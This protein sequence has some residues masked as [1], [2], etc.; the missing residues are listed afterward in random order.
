MIKENALNLTLDVLYLR[1]LS[2][3]PYGKIRC[4]DALQEPPESGVLKHFVEFETIA[5]ETQIDSILST[6]ATQSEIDS[7][8]NVIGTETRV[9]NIPNWATWTEAE[10]LAWWET[11]L[12]DTVVDAIGNLADAKEVL[13]DQNQAIKSMARMLIALR[14]KNWPNLGS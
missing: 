9:S 11:N 2:F 12:S 7:L 14:D 4:W 10:A 1:L 8:G 13:K 6:T 3:D 5:T